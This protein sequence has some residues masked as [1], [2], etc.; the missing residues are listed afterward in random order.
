MQNE[1][2]N[3][4]LINLLVIF[5]IYGCL[6]NNNPINNSNFTAPASDYFPLSPS[7]VT[8][9]QV[10]GSVT[11]YDSTG[12]VS[13]LQISDKKYSLQITASTI[14][15]GMVAHPVFEINNGRSKLA[16]YL[17]NSGNWIVGF[18]RD[19]SSHTIIVLPQ[20]FTVGKEWVINPGSPSDEQLKCKI[21]GA[22]DS[23][24]NS[25]GKTYSSVVDLLVT[26]KDSLSFEGSFG[27]AYHTTSVV[28][29]IYLAKGVGIVGATLDD[30]E[31][32]YK[33]YFDYGRISASG[34]MGV[35]K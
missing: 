7:Q 32:I 29:N 19:T 17:S 33:S 22:F 31:Q 18:E 3:L 11:R 5:S 26:H 23:Y 14:I 6:N 21:A 1:L 28:G 13:F 20:I 16:G 10:S 25:V 2:K 9:A 4:L 35:T 30:Y 24:T 34:T 12:V 8:N 15:R 27:S